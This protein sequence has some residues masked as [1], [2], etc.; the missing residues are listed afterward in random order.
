MKPRPVEIVLCVETSATLKEIRDH[1]RVQKSK[2][3]AWGGKYC[4][5]VRADV[6]LIKRLTAETPGGG[7]E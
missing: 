3:T 6:S 7:T 4:K 5:L 2:T 1:M